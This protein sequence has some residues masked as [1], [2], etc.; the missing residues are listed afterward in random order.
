ME[1]ALEVSA[2]MR[3]GA[4]AAAQGDAPHAVVGAGVLQLKARQF[5]P[6]SPQPLHRRAAE[7]VLEQVLQGASRQAA[8]P[9]QIAKADGVRELSA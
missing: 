6:L 1:P 9:L 4:V 3:W 8:L 7:A 2:E 5:Q